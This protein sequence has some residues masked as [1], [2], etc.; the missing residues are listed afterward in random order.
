MKTAIAVFSC[1]RY[2]QLAVG[3]DGCYH[4]QPHA[5]QEDA[6]GDVAA[7]RNL[8]SG[9][10]LLTLMKK[11]EHTTFQ[12]RWS[13]YFILFLLAL[14]SWPFSPFSPVLT[15]SNDRYQR[16]LS[17]QRERH[18]PLKTAIAVF[19]CH[20]YQQLTVGD[21]GCYHQQPHALQED[22]TG[23]VAACRNL[24]SGEGLL[25]L[26]KKAEHTTF[27]DRWSAYFILFLLALN[28][29]PFSPFS[30]VLTH[31]NDR[32]QR[33]LSSQRERHNPLKTAIAVFSCHR[34]Q[35]LTVGDDGCYHQQPHALQED[36]TGDVAACRN[37]LSGEGLLTLMKKAEHTTFQDR[38]SA[39]FI[40]F[41]LSLNP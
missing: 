24:L 14:N 26:M 11:A 18:N 20:R 19:S 8:L 15:H 41:L 23:D 4:Q 5:L 16:Y 25:T 17:S 34:Y 38:W 2:Q 12:D 3:D 28:S 22:A 1:H 7:C 29:W 6:T 32:Y 27:Q 21:D 37:L 36:A 30:P 33:Y 10:G 31:S 9:E 40:L 39:Y 13:A 35:Q